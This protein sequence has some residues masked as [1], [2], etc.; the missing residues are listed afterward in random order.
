MTSRGI[1]DS[2]NVAHAAARGSR[3]DRSSPAAL[4]ARFLQQK[5]RPTE[6]YVHRVSREGVWLWR[7]PLRS[8]WSLREA[9]CFGR[10]LIERDDEAAEALCPVLS[11]GLDDMMFRPFSPPP[12]TSFFPVFLLLLLFLPPSLV[13]SSLFHTPLSW[14]SPHDPCYHLDGRPRHC[15]SEFINAAYGVPVNASH[16]LQGSDYDSNVTTLTDLHNPHNLTCWLTHRGTDIG[17]WELTVPLGRRFEITYISLQ[18]CHQGEPSDPISISI[19]KSMDFGRTWRPMQHYSSNCLGDFGLPSQT[20]AQ[21][22]HQETEPLCSDPRPLQKQRGG[23][24]LAFST[25]DGRPSSPDFDHSHALQDWVTATDIR[26]VFHQVSKVDKTGGSD[27][28]DESRWR[29]SREDRRETGIL[30]SRSGHKGRAEDQVNKLNTDS[31]LGF[32]DRETKHSRSKGDKGDKQGRKGPGKGSGQDEDGH[33]VTSKEGVD[34]FGIDTLT[35]SK[36]GAKGRGRGHKKENDHWLPC[37]NGGCNWTLEGR[38]RGNK[39]RELRKRRNNNLNTR[40]GARSMQAAM[41]SVFNPPAHASLALSDLQVGGRCKCNGHASRCR[42]DD[43]GRALCVCEHHTAGPDCD[44]CE[45][46]HFDRPW[47]RAT[48]TH[49]NPCVACECNDHSNKCRFSMEVFQQ[50]G[51]RS[52]GVCQKCRHHTA[53]RHCQYCQNGYTRDHSKPLD[54]RKACQP[55]HCHPLGAVGRWCNQTSGQCLCREGVTGL[56]CNRCAPGYKQGKSPLRPCIPPFA[57][58]L[59]GSKPLSRALILYQTQREHELTT[60]GKPHL[61]LIWD[62]RQIKWIVAVLISS[63]DPQ[64]PP[65]AL[66]HVRSP[67]ANRTSAD[68]HTGPNAA[69]QT[70]NSPS[71]RNHLRLCLESPAPS[72]CRHIQ[73]HSSSSHQTD[74]RA[75]SSS[76][77]SS[78]IQEVAPTPVFQPQYSI[79]VRFG[80]AAASPRPRRCSR[81]PPPSGSSRNVPPAALGA[82]E[83]VSYCQPSQVK[84]RMNLE[85]YCLKDYVLKV[86]VRGMERSGPWWQFSISIQTVYRTGSNSRVRRGPHS[87]WVPDRDL[88]CGC[89]ALHVGRTYLLIGAEEGERGWGPEESRLVADRSTLAL[90]WR[91]HWSPKLRGFRGHDKRGRCPEKSPDSPRREQA[92]AQ[93]GYI[94][95]HLLTEK[96][97]DN[98]NTHSVKEDETRTSAEPHTHTPTEVEPTETTPAPSSPALFCSTTLSE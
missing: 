96:D 43:K 9:S 24:V 20:V 17:E 23:M 1:L 80:G 56:R 65:R 45:D 4:V 55:C 7:R 19:L 61:Q 73:H 54:H 95:P 8:V 59:N 79:D 75:P 40:Q 12:S 2:G 47:H 35:S 34:F 64:P 92:N 13:S 67:A 27:R 76:S 52:G 89:P 58:G 60:A 29:D 91:E 44:V 74:Q 26:V 81:A 68:N 98:V 49:P 25:L 62:E 46:F 32:F 86:Q 22:R 50:S 42:R 82:E 10:W 16:S 85:T 5:S 14:T 66:I 87:L 6:R 30:R 90:Q 39:G 83:C 63:T 15:L 93:A 97:T 18:F 88:G 38:S 78:R 69:A 51:R 21:T 84:V 37:P 48:P 70:H 36:K 71:E 77:S 28:A 3:S 53:G 57:R 31:A 11:Y 33:N 41:P 72:Q 94:P